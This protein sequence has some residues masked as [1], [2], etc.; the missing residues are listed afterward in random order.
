MACATRRIRR[1]R[2]G[3]A[4]RLAAGN[5]RLRRAGQIVRRHDS[6]RTYVHCFPIS[7]D[8]ACWA[9]SKSAA[10]SPWP[11]TTSAPPKALGLYRNYLSLLDYSERDTLTG[12]LNRKTFDENLARSWPE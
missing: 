12:M 5:G 1:H 9:C 3:R 2:R 8:R 6:R 7:V 4:A 11:T 10:T